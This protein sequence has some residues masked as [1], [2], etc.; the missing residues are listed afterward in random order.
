MTARQ[1]PIETKTTLHKEASLLAKSGD[2]THDPAV[3][4]VPMLQQQPAGIA[5]GMTDD[6]GDDSR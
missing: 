1:Q 4:V 3:G 2:Y 5:S 6:P